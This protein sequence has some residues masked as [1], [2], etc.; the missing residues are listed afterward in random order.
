MADALDIVK[1]AMKR[2]NIISS[3]E[4]P[5]NVDAIDCLQM[6]NRILAEYPARGCL[7]VSPQLSGLGA[8]WAAGD[9]YLQAIEDVLTLRIAKPFGV[10]VDAIIER[11]A[12]RGDRLILRH[13]YDRQVFGVDNAL[14]T[15][16]MSG[17]RNSWDGV[18]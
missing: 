4:E 9:Q 7:E 14:Q 12:G 6:L 8:I 3:T 18:A 17:T 15:T 2:L 16:R 13:F 5:S 11:D 10:P 1:A